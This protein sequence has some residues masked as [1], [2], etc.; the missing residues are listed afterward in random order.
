MTYAWCARGRLCTPRMVWLDRNY[1]EPEL[2]LGASNRV[3][4]PSRVDADRWS[5][6]RF[7]GRLG[8]LPL[9]RTEGGRRGLGPSP[10]P[11]TE[12]PAAFRLCNN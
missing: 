4:R 9:S 8:E 1:D 12:A 11:K 3:Q 10:Q 2:V 6:Q 5:R 7:R